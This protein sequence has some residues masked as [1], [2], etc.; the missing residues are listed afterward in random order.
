MPCP[1]QVNSLKGSEFEWLYAIITA[2]NDGDLQKY[3][4]VCN[5]YA[6]QLNSQPALVQ[7]YDKLR[8]KAALMSL[9]RLASSLHPEAARIPGVLEC[10]LAFMPLQMELVFKKPA[11][12][13]TIPL[14]EIAERTKLGSHDAELLV[15]KALA[16]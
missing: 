12:M 1:G 7:N 3:D 2:F 8:E 16:V 15:M 6:R 9:V 11:E 4:E 13:R 14:A 10:L 5:T